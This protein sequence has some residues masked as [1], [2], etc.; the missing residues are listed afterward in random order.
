MPTIQSFNTLRARSYLSRLPLFTRFINVV[1]FLVWLLGVQSVWDVRQWGTLYPAEINF[2]TGEK[3]LL[4]TLL[5]GDKAKLTRRNHHSTSV[6]DV[7]A[8]TLQLF[9]YA[10]QRYS[11]DAF[12]GEDGM[13][14]W[15]IDDLCAVLRT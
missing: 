4:G 2:A 1:I 15:H 6:D 5:E 8:H 10:G 14:I 7:P 3:G 12:D 9:P 13:R 11:L